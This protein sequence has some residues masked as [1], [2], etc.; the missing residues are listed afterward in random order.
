MSLLRN[1]SIRIRFYVLVA[2]SLATLLVAS[3]LT[4]AI[5][6][7]ALYDFKKHG[8]SQVVIASVG[9]SE[10]FREL[11]NNG[12]LTTE[13]A[14]RYAKEALSKMRF[15]GGNY[16]NILTSDGTGVM[17]PTIP[18]FAGK[19]MNYLKDKNGAPIVV[20]HIK[21]INNPEGEGFNYYWWPKTGEEVAS[22]KF[23]FNKLY[24]PWDWI[25]SAGDFTDSIDTVV[26]KSVKSSLLVLAITALFLGGISFAVMRSILTPL[27]RTV[28]SMNKITGEK[29]DLTE[30]IHEEGKDE[31]SELANKFN[32]MQLE[33]Q[34]VVR[35][36]DTVNASLNE[37]AAALVG[38][39]DRTRQ[40]TERQSSE[41]DQVVT[42]VNEMSAT[43][44][45]IANN[46]SHAAD[47]TNSTNKQMDTGKRNIND[48]IASMD[49]LVERIASSSD[50]IAELLVTAEK[51]NKVLEVI[52]GVAEQTNLLALNAAIEAARAG[53]QGRGFAVVADE[54]RTLAKRVQESTHEIDE[55]IQQI[56][57][58]AE[59]ASKS[60]Q[61]VVNVA[62]TTSEKTRLTGEALEHVIRSV[63]EI[64]EL[65]TQIA[66]AA[67][68]QAATTEE[69]NR[70][71]IGINNITHD[72]ADDVS[73]MKSATDGLYD[74][75][76]QMAQA[77]DRFIR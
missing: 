35:E 20:N 44:N 12:E 56:H 75:A 3:V 67:E 23:A 73:S 4:I 65:N 36:V 70:N 7:D 29:L 9:V 45:E 66:T 26:S 32:R 34:E 60:M 47:I 33:V 41:M 46:T 42:A 43:V 5:L 48:T 64:N 31:L 8:I 52:N 30:R 21:S 58:G 68:Q 15:D 51:I 19:D 72:S 24:K 39:A 27:N 16:I 53:E 49:T 37:S 6:R 62:Q 38:I 10:Y 55:I 50:T 2:V 63:G 71:L 40:G 76:R 59:G 18:G 14:Q 25:F 77:I 57:A 28:T 61:T 74:M 13:Q 11:E 69:I 22:Q 17:H 1:S 54:V